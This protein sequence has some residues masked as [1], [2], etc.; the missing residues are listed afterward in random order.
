MLGNEVEFSTLEIREEQYK[1]AQKRQNVLTVITGLGLNYMSLDA[2]KRNKD[3]RVIFIENQYRMLL[4][5]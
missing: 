2:Q 4:I 1:Q 3:N 5:V